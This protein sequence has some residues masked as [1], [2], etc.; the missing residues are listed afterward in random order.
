MEENI[1]KKCEEG[2]K[3]EKMKEERNGVK[4]ERMVNI[5]YWATDLF[6]EIM[7]CS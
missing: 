3:E 5:R 2:R 4:V 7:N 1:Q 6:V